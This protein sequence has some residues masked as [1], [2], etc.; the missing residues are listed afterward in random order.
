[1][2]VYLLLGSNKG[3]RL[4]YL[5]LAEYFISKEAGKIT[6]KSAVYVTQPWEKLNQPNYLNQAIEL[7][8]DKS[9]LQLLKVL[10]KL[11]KV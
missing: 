11:K 10:Q 2:I 9:P 6:Q 4:K 7:E 8:T 3:D 1:M 5:M